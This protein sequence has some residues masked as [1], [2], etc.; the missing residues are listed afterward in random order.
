MIMSNQTCPKCGAEYVKTDEYSW[1]YFE[2]STMMYP[3]DT[4]VHPASEGLQC[5]RNQL[6][7]SA[8]KLAAV[9]E[10]RDSNKH[11][12][13]VCAVVVHQLDSEN[14]C[15]RGLLGEIAAWYGEIR[16]GGS[17]DYISKLGPIIKRIDD[18]S[19]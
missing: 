8:D 10:E 19:E 18:G 13:D 2:C 16:K 3:D 12:Y 4:E 6:S 11:L 5:L 1:T 9:T 15:L 14:N 17:F 7:A